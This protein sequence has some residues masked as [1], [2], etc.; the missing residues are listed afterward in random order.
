MMDDRMGNMGSTQGVKDNNSPNTRN[1][2]TTRQNRPDL[3][4]SSI[5]DA[6]PQPGAVTC[7]EEAGVNSVGD[8]LATLVM[9]G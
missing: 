3:N 4:A 1:T 6:S 5:R 9:G 2:P 7:A 8:K